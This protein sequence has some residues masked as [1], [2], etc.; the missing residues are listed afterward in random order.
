MAADG[1][2]TFTSKKISLHFSSHKGQRTLR[3]ASPLLDGP[4]G[5]GIEAELQLATPPQESLTIATSWAEDRRAFYY[6]S[7]FNCLPASGRF[8]FGEKVFVL[9][10]QRDLGVLDW[11]RGV[12][13]RDNTW[14]WGSASGYLDGV[15]FGF[16]LG[17]GFTDRSPASE[18]LLLYDGI[19]HKLDQVYF[20]FDPSD[21]LKPWKVSSNDKRL[22]LNF[23][24]AVDRN[25]LA[26]FWLIRSEQHQVFGYF[27]GTAVLDDGRVLQLKDFP[28]FAEEVK[29]L[30]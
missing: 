30:W 20:H 23:R 2:I 21:W 1:E 19:G 13:T 3:F 9:D 12:W 8:R 10:P 27:S 7:K 17:Y 22:T 26:D 24:P 15:P 11:G 18:T 29:N 16:N 5:R 14:Y 4:Y 25:S 6:N 28:G